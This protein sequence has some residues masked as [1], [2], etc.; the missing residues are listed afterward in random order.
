M[1]R[2]PAVAEFE[3]LPEAD[4]LGDFPHPRETK[5]LFGHAQAEQM[6]A[7]ALASGRVHHA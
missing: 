4:R 7:E 2:A 3:E 1:A 5:Q 6:L